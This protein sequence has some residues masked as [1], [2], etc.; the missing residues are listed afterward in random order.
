MKAGVEPYKITSQHYDAAY[1]AKQDLVDLPFYL[2]L[3]RKSGGPV[4]EIAC[5]TGRVLLQVAREGIPIT[6]V[7]NSRPMLRVLKAH[8]QTE[9]RDVQ[10]KIT[11][12]EGDMRSFRLRKKYPLV[13]IP[14]RPMQHMYTLKDQLQALTTAAFHL[15]KNGTLAF[16]VF[17]PKFKSMD[18]GIGQEVLDLE[19]P[20]DSDSVVRRYFRKDSLDKIK[21]VFSFTFIFRTYAAGKLVREESE[22]FQLSYYTYP[23]L[24]ALFLLAGLEPLAEYGSFAKEPLDNSAQQM[25]FLLKKAKSHRPRRGSLRTPVPSVRRKC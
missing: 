10:R 19:W 23:H 25:I 18:E 11:L 1:A 9:P 22:P 16:D 2:D 14:F 17:Y 15:H 3:A 5:G 21:Q 6:G 13:I 20:R 8:V 24:R 12:H 7:D 4:L